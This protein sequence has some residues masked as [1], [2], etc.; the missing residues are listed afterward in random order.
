M[1][2]EFEAL[3]KMAVKGQCQC[4]VAALG[5]VPFPGIFINELSVLKTSSLVYTIV[6]IASKIKPPY[7]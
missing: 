4:E 3:L 6:E 5:W 7:C 1:P 2:T